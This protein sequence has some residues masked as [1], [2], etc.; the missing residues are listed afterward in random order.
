[1]CAFLFVFWQTKGPQVIAAINDA[2]L[3]RASQVLNGRLA[4]DRLDISLSGT[5]IAH[6]LVVYDNQNHVIASCD[7]LAFDFGFADL[8]RGDFAPS[9]IKRV[10]VEGARVNL[11]YDSK[12][13]WNTEELLKPTPDGD[14]M[15]F[16]GE[17]KVYRSSV[18]V[19]GPEG[20]SRFEQVEGTL[21]FAAYPD[22]KT[23]LAGKL[24]GSSIVA[25]GLWSTSGAMKMNWQADRLPIPLI[26]SYM[27]S[28]DKTLFHEGNVYDLSVVLSREKG[29]VSIEADGM[30]SGLS[31]DSSGV[32]VTEMQGKVR[33]AENVL[34]IEDA[35]LLFAGQNLAASGSI[36][37]STSQ[38]RLDLKIKG[39]SFDLA[40][41]SG[42]S[43]VAGAISFQSVIK[44]SPS[45]LE[46][47]GDFS[48]PAGTFS[49]TAFTDASGMFRF[50]NGA[51]ALSAVSLNSLGGNLSLAGTWNQKTGM[52]EQDIAGKNLDAAYL[53][54]KAVLG[55]VDLKVRVTGRD[56]ANAAVRGSFAMP[57][58][59]INGTSLEKVS[60]DFSK[61]GN[62][63][64]F[65]D[66]HFRTAGQKMTAEGKVLLGGEAP[67]LD[68]HVK[69][70]GMELSAI[71][72]EV[73]IRGAL[74]F[75]AAV[76]GTAK[77]YILAGSLQMPSG[78][79]GTLPFADVEGEFAFADNVLKL[80]DFQFNLIDDTEAKQKMT[81]A[82]EI[83]F[84]GNDPILDLRIHS[85]G[86]E[87]AA[88]NRKLPISGQLSFQALVSGTTGKPVLIGSFQI[89]SGQIGA[90]PFSE[91]SGDFHFASDVLK[92]QAVRF[93]ALGGSV[94][95]EGTIDKTGA[96][97][98]QIS[99]QNLETTWLTDGDIRG[100]ANL[101]AN[102]MGEG[103]WEKATAEGK[104][105]MQAGMIKNA[106]F[107]SLNLEFHKQGEHIE[108]P[109][110]DMKFLRGF[111][112][113]TGY[114]D[115][116][117]LIIKLSPAK[118][119]KSRVLGIS[120]LLLVGTNPL[121]AILGQTL[122]EQFPLG[123]L[124]I[125]INGLKTNEK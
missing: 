11:S 69:S 27:P 63:L 101:V 121:A 1:M 40:V 80:Q 25:E 22:M 46:I 118:N 68:M 92:L 26:L 120:T 29:P 34:R 70:K 43:P 19:S 33:L 93:N 14:S 86:V 89:P 52:F 102:V 91:G 20:N 113:G 123:V 77:N 74:A 122:S 79:F 114:S 61:T 12:G 32:K 83:S 105:S 98:Q 4:A 84:A 104:I 67:G 59:V 119:R 106:E 115:G 75:Q 125:R 54:D 78:Q 41:L 90:L 95:S 65:A 9:K 2:I 44:G 17:V 18:A 30:V 16:R 31:A 73:P 110:L 71:K 82:G 116:D 81:A 94:T 87:A 111:V 76:S 112:K 53:S 50:A 117:Y 28:V 23:G 37:F 72:P 8:L 107:S 47:S 6:K 7:E 124:K 100:K 36:D 85:D 24:G 5:T 15:Q 57:A 49:S 108:I 45:N 21:N 99:G 62:A 64:E 48:I 51:L 56:V 58:A 66:L 96:F 3:T 13:R 35:T 10:T 38:T 39:E 109:A 55:N 103:G 97:R 88:I 60:G 42:S